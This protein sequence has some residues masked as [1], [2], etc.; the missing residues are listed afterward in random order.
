MTL[1]FLALLGRTKVQ[2]LGDF[3]EA[4]DFATV[5]PKHE[6]S[7]LFRGSR[8]CRSRWRVLLL[9]RP[10]WRLSFRNDSPQRNVQRTRSMTLT[11]SP[12]SLL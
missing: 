10:R 7:T 4:G 5:Y 1:S 9:L 8:L 6:T 3:A 2:V 12:V 11:E